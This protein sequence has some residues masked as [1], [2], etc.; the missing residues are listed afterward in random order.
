MRKTV[1]HYHGKGMCEKCMGYF[2]H[3]RMVNING[4]IYV[5]CTKCAEK[6]LKIDRAIRSTGLGM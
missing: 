4:G 6:F 1:K 2:S 3:M 5:M